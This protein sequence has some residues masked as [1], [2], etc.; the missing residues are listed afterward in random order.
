MSGLHISLLTL[1]ALIST[2]LFMYVWACVYVQAEGILYEKVN[3][4]ALVFISSLL[5]GVCMY[6]FVT[7]SSCLCLLRSKADLSIQSTWPPWLQAR[8]G[9]HDVGGK[10]GRR[11][12]WEKDG[13][14]HLTVVA[15]LL[16]WKRTHG[17]VNTW[18]LRPQEGHYYKCRHLS[19]FEGFQIFIKILFNI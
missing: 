1:R 6:T 19:Y 12:R 4:C 18:Y 11:K 14:P 5:G 17:H 9:R 8:G 7:M 15:D 2:T 16:M 13:E 3:K 10:D